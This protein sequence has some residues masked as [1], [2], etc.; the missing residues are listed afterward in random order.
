MH[1]WQAV[2]GKR[3]NLVIKLE[4]NNPNG[5]GLFV[6]NSDKYK[7]KIFWRGVEKNTKGSLLAGFKKKDGK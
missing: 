2:W 3:L 1:I 5:A 6:I 7:G 4:K